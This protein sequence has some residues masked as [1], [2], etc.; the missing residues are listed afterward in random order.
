[1][2]KYASETPTI[3]AK[4]HLIF[5]KGTYL[6]H[7]NTWDSDIANIPVDISDLSISIKSQY[8][9]LEGMKAFK[10]EDKKQLDSIIKTMQK[11]HDEQSLLVALDGIKVCASVSRGDVTQTDIDESQIMHMQ[12]K[13]LRSWLDNDKETTEDW[14][15]KSVAL[16]ESLSF[17]YG[18]PFIQK[19]THELYAEWLAENNRFDEAIE[20]YDLTLKRAKNRTVTLEG[21]EKLLTE[22]KI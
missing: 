20:Q 13:A 5:L 6:V 3:R 8:Y 17:S 14:L 21:K 12:I 19:P 1:M 4:V 16:Q 15:K 7:T 10:K 18:P 11:N 9:F 22:N 2:E